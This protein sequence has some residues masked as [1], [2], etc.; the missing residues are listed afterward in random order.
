VSGE[1]RCIPCTPDGAIGFRFRKPSLFRDRTLDPPKPKK[2]MFSPAESWVMGL[3]FVPVWWV[4][5]GLYGT[6]PLLMSIALAGML[7]YLGVVCVR[8]LREDTVQLVRTKLKTRG[9]WRAPGVAVF[10][11][12]FL[13]TGLWAH[14]AAVRVQVWRGERSLR[15]LAI[16]G[17]PTDGL[18]AFSPVEYL[19]R[20]GT[21]GMQGAAGG[22]AA[23]ESGIAA[24][25]FV[26]RYGLAATPG[27]DRGLGALHAA[28]GD[29]L[30]ATGRFEPAAEAY[31]AAVA[32]RP[33]AAH[34][35]FNLA[36]LLSQLGRLEPAVEHLKVA[37]ELAP[38]DAEV[39]NNLGFLLL[40]RGECT[41]AESELRRALE[42]DPDLAH[43]WF[44]L[45]RLRFEDGAE[46]EA[47]PLFER[48]A[49]LDPAYAAWLEEQRG[50]SG[51]P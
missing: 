44:N 46:A 15:A 23:I 48:A 3:G 21:G 12:G 17:G 40:T 13:L 32:R 11:I 14:S 35:R 20:Y 31:E 36:R 5:R 9:R 4:L 30:A 28:R 22:L 6:I 43:A 19:D 42:L 29:Q 37:A 47:W 41:A 26:E 39:A 24:W 8:L 16:A 50:A 18:S 34:L 49:E 45:G 51:P 25:E 7:L 27:T 1:T 38:G 2:P 33:N 10:S